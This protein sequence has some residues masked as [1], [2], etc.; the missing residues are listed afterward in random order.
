MKFVP[1]MTPQYH[2]GSRGIHRGNTSPG[3][4]ANNA[5]GRCSKEGAGLELV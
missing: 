3:S 5:S 1:E 2:W 4:N